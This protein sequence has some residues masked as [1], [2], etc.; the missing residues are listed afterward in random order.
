MTRI[1]ALLAAALLASLALAVATPPAAA[2][3]CTTTNPFPPSPVGGEVG[4]AYTFAAATG[5]NAF[6]FGVRTTCAVAGQ[7][8][9]TVNAQ[10]VF[11]IGSECIEIA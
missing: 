1:T 11:L 6:A 7:A 9:S 4:R 8:V 10:C 3:N 2:I 5:Y